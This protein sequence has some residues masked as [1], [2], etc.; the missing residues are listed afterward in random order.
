MIER[1]GMNQISLPKAS[2][3]QLNRLKRLVR[4]NENEQKQQ[5]RKY[6][7]DRFC[8]IVLEIPIIP[9]RFCG[10]RTRCAGK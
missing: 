2:E 8:F 5:T 3:R 10:S 6:Q 4:N 1:K 7:S 9:N